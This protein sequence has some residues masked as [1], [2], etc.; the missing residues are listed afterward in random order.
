MN[1][2]LISEPGTDRREA[3]VKALIDLM[4][5]AYGPEEAVKRLEARVNAINA[6]KS[7]DGCGMHPITPEKSQRQGAEEPQEPQEPK[8]GHVWQRVAPAE[9]YCCQS[10][11]ASKVEWRHNYTL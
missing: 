5:V 4:I 9:V 3:E 10:C 11:G 2:D 7:V 1:M 6:S 8:C